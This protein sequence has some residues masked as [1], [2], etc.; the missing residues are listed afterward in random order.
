MPEPNLWH[1]ERAHW[2]ARRLRVAGVD[3]A[4]R[5]PLAG[6]VVAAAVILPDSYDIAGI[7]DSKALTEKKREAAFTR[8]VADAEKGF[9]ASGV[10]FSVG[11]AFPDEV[12]RINILQATH[13]AMRRAVAGLCVPPDAVLVDGLPVR[14]LHAHCTAIVKGD[15]LSASIAAA[16]IL[17]KVSRDRYMTEQDA[18]Y[19]EYG[20]ARHKGYCAPIHLAAL[21]EYGPCPIH[22]YS[23]GPVAQASLKF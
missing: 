2:D 23:F 4:G 22:R 21:A 3:E 11:W 7:T 15:A 16:S 6:P 1:F 20:F 13:V 5:G 17:A 19:P 14:D 18:L 10:A 8:I 9:D 12:D